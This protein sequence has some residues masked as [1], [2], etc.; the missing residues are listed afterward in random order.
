MFPL[1]DSEKIHRDFAGLWR[2]PHLP[3]RSRYVFMS[4]SLGTVKAMSDFSNP[5]AKAGI[6]AV[7][8]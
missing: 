3:R 7:I 2:E 1:H 5:R 4:T 8:N 6:I